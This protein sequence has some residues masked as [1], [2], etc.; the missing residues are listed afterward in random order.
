MRTISTRRDPVNYLLTT[1]SM[2]PAA[3]TISAH[4]RSN[5]RFADVG[6][7]RPGLHSALAHRRAPSSA[8]PNGTLRRLHGGDGPGQARRQCHHRLHPKVV[9][10]VDD[11][12]GP[13]TRSG[14]SGRMKRSPWATLPNTW[15]RARWVYRF[16]ARSTQMGPAPSRPARVAVV[17]P[18]GTAQR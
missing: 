8:A 17:S 10:P 5:G 14:G 11:G 2:P 3:A 16:M 12:A 18:P 4:R 7:H 1:M 9:A 13:G 6:M 15:P